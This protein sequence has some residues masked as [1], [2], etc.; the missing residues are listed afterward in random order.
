MGFPRLVRISS[1]G[2]DNISDHPSVTVIDA[3]TG[4][5]IALMLARNV[6]ELG[7][8]PLG[9][10]IITWQRPSRDENGDQAKNLM[11]WRAIEEVPFEADGDEHNIVGRFVQKSQTG[12][13]LQYTYDEK[14]CAREVANEVQFYQSEDLGRVWSKLRVEGVADFAISPGDHHSIAVFIPER[15]VYKLS[16]LPTK[17]L[18]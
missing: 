2:F 6:F 1:T 16:L 5:R 9:T 3:S 12:W 15:K 11:V 14:Y 8:S 18:A 17:D 7:F 10:F 4:D 13:N